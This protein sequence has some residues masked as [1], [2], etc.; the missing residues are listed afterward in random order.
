V[1]RPELHH[2]PFLPGGEDG[3][4]VVEHSPGAVWQGAFVLSN[5]VPHGWWELQIVVL[6]R[7]LPQKRRL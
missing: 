5:R 3:P 7:K 4:L 2:F 6:G 1:I